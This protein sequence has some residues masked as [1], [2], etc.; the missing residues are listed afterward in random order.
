MSYGRPVR[1]T[2]HVL[3]RRNHFRA[4]VYVDPRFAR[5]Q[6]RAVILACLVRPV[7]YRLA[8]FLAQC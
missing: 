1:V 6:M 3:R 5:M 4:L 8:G 7:N 2:Q